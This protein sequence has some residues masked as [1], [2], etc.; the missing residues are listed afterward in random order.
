MLLIEQRQA[1]IQHSASPCFSNV[2]SDW[3]HRT[4]HLAIGAQCHRSTAVSR[5]PGSDRLSGNEATHHSQ[6]GSRL[7]GLSNHRTVSSVKSVVA[8]SDGQPCFSVITDQ[9]GNREVIPGEDLQD[10]VYTVENSDTRSPGLCSKQSRSTSG[11]EHGNVKFGQRK[12]ASGLEPG[13]SGLRQ[14]VAEQPSKQLCSTS[15]G[16]YDFTS[17]PGHLEHFDLLVTNA[18]VNIICILHCFSMM[19]AVM[20]VWCGSCLLHRID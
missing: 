17:G 11:S 14:S 8:S 5:A 15:H 18:E 16:D 13:M 1:A 19:I 12:S 2:D 6:G 10:C 9:Q 7:P 20:S 3:L 4:E